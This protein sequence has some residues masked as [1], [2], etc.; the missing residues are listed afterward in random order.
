MR[1]TATPPL[2]GAQYLADALQTAGISHVF[3]VPVV[4]T[5]ALAEMD[6]RGVVGVMTHGE[7]AAAYMADGYARASRRVGIC[8]AQVIGA[9]NLAAGLRD[10]YLAGSPVVALTGGPLPE[11][12]HRRVYQEID[13]F[14][15]FVPLTKFNARVDTVARLPDLLQQA[16]R[17]ATTGRPGPVH[18]EIAGH[19]GQAADGPGRLDCPF[20]PSFAAVPPLRT[21]AEPAAIE[22]ALHWLHRAERP[23]AVVGGGVVWSGAEAEVLALAEALQLPVATSLNAKGTIPEDHPL[24]VGVPGSYARSCANRAVAE[25]DLVFFIGSGTGSQVTHCW[26]LPRPGTRVIQLD[27]EPAEL[28]RHYANVVS[29]WGDARTVLR[30]LRAAAWPPPARRTWLGRI[31]QLVADWRAD[32]QPLRLSDAVPIRPERLC[33]ELQEALPPDAILVSETGHAGIWTG[34]QVELHHARQRYLRAAGSLGW[35]LPAAL[36]AKCACPDRPVICF[37]GDGGFYYH[38]AELETAVRYGISAVIVVNNNRSLNQETRIFAQAYGG[39]QTSGFKMWQFEDVNLARV[40]EAFGCH[41][42]RVEQPAEI[43]PALERALA[44]GRPAVLDVVTDI[45]ALPPDPWTPDI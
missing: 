31:A 20:E 5:P 4:L 8:M 26:R 34:T 41:A 25:A 36:G 40:A 14:P 23:I 33:R 45:R 1:L 44:S 21:A 30:Q 6:R 39:Q 17:V 18:L 24:S 19:F 15:L 7:K 13:D 29:L 38:I 43:R 16:F 3:F 2:T 9:A 37:S 28:G 42:E 12:R 10:A 32:A 27:I 11:S 35:G 22:Q